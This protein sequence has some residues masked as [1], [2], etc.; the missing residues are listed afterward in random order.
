MELVKAA[1]KVVNVLA[2]VREGESVLVLA[3]SIVDR[4][5]LDAV[6]GVAHT[7][8]GEVV[9]VIYETR[10][11]VNI[12]PPKPVAAAMASGD[13][14]IDFVYQYIIHTNAFYNALNSGARIC[15]LTGMN[16]DMMIR[17]IGRIDY[18]AMCA[19]G[20][21]LAEII[22]S[23]KRLK[24]YSD[25]GTRLVM[26]NDPSRPVY[27]ND[28][29][30]R[31]RGELKFL[32]GQISWAPIEESIN[33][34][35]VLDGFLWPPSEIGV[36]KSPVRLTIENGRI[37]GVEGGLE[38]DVFRR[39]LSSFDDPKMYYI[40]HVSFGFN[41][42]ARLTGVPL[43]DE[44]VYGCIEFG[45]GSQ[46]LRFRGRIGTAS[47]H[48]DGNCLNPEVYVDD[49]CLLRNGRFVHPELVDLDRRLMS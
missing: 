39:W 49:E 44:R 25:R 27:H 37:V 43:E 38:A 20:D 33:G 6:C 31:Q 42:G 28:G 47:S 19:L 3:D 1:Y 8:G 9:Q 13:V 46:S 45:F 30:V 34:T 4:E 15:D 14:I 7:V 35:I 40:A 12:E 17:L 24:V 16:S 41:P 11:R 29:K 48:S 23:T 21:K 36:L 10:P 22:S 2:G 26:E 5:M 32:G 18:E